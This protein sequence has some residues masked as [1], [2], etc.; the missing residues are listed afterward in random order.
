[1][2]MQAARVEE[3]QTGAHSVIF[4]VSE[5]KNSEHNLNYVSGPITRG[6]KKLS[7]VK[8]GNSIDILL[9]FQ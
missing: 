4:V 2:L 7:V 3:F 6:M 9:Y 1:M 8:C 5:W